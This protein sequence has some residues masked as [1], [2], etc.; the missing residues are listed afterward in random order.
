MHH[1][2][3][4]DKDDLAVAVR[5]KRQKVQEYKI[6]YQQGNLSYD[7]LAEAGR[8]LSAALYEYSKARFPS[9]TVRRL[10][11]QSLIR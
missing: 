4:S 1:N 11:Y 3:V 6:G 7:D 9:I 2:I 5:L 8:E 10:P